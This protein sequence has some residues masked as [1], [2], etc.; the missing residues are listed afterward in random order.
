MSKKWGFTKLS[1][2]E[3]VEKRHAGLLKPDGAYV[4]YLT[5]HGPLQSHLDHL[6]ATADE[7]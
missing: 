2:E 6:A 4:K 3:Y 7:D 5:Q 1:R